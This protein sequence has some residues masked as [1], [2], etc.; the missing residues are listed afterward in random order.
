[1]IVWVSSFPRS[2]NTFLRI[3][4]KRLYAVRSSVVYDVDGVAERLGRDLVGFAERPA[5]IEAMRE[6]DEVHFVKTHRQRDQQVDEADRAICLVRDGRDALVSWARMVS[7]ADSSRFETE[8]RAMITRR[9]KVGTGSWGRNI[10]S[11]LRPSV[12]H[13]TL[14]RYEDVVR[15]PRSAVE[16]VLS[17]L[18][19]DLRPLVDAQIPSFA[20]LQQTDDRFFRRGLTASHRD[21]MPDE[22]H[23]L[24]WSQPDNVVAMRLLGYADPA[25]DSSSSVT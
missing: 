22:L 12:P 20:E 9:D 2:G 18:V 10:L 14:L 13:R 4:L 21:E 24:F 6:S 11:W 19:A 23:K 7:E 17:V 15:E 8:L 16:R 5:T 3:V 25:A 1:M